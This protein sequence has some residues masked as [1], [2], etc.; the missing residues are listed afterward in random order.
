MAKQIC[1]SET[2]SRAI[3]FEIPIEQIDP[4]TIA[5]LD[6]IKLYRMPD[7]NFCEFIERLICQNQ[8]EIAKLQKRIKE[9]AW[10]LKD[11]I[12]IPLH[13]LGHLN[14]RELLTILEI[15]SEAEFTRVAL[16]LIKPGW[17]I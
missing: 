3:Q 9:R 4:E 16:S 13:R 8:D 7:K 15:K 6:H 5:N 2:V 1:A 11:H 12:G 14:R 17:R 10:N